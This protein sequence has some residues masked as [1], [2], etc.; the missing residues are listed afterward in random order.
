MIRL[1]HERENITEAPPLGEKSPV[2]LCGHNPSVL[3]LS[4]ATNFILSA[5]GREISRAAAAGGAAPGLNTQELKL[6]LHW[7]NPSSANQLPSGGGYSGSL[8]VF[9]CWDSRK[10]LCKAHRETSKWQQPGQKRQVKENGQAFIAK[11]A[12]G[13]KIKEKAKQ[14]ILTRVNLCST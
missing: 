7:F 8:W 14:T 5:K 10:P 9:Y 13:C 12:H 1:W 6:Q 3:T 11:A 2:L 4:F